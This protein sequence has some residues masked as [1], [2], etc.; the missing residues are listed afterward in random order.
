MLK[1]CDVGYII[2]NTPTA[3]MYAPTLQ[4]FNTPHDTFASDLA[5]AHDGLDEAPTQHSHGGCRAGS[6]SAAR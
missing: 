6:D 4:H 1:T 3:E 5:P 2:K